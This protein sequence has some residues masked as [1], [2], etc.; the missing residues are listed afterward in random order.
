MNIDSEIGNR[1]MLGTD[2]LAERPKAMHQYVRI[3]ISQDWANTVCG[4]LIAECLVNLL[5][6][7]VVLV[8]QL[9]IVSTDVPLLIHPIIKGT[10]HTFAN[11]LVAVGEWSVGMKVQT[12]DSYSLQEPDQTIV[13]GNATS[14]HLSK[15]IACI[16]DGWKAWVGEPKNVP[17]GSAS[18]SPNP[19]G[20][21][22]TA[23]LAAGEI[24]KRT[25]GLR[26]GRYLDNHAYSLWNNSMGS[27]WEELDAGPE[28]D[29]LGLPPFVLVG[30]GAVGNALAYVLTHLENR[31]MYPVLIDDDIYDKT[32]LNRCSLAG[33]ENLTQEKTAVLA[34]RLQEA[35]IASFPFS[36]DLKRFVNDARVGMRTDV[37]E[38][39]GAGVY[40][41]VVSCVDK[42]DGRQDIQGLH[43]QWLLGGSTFDLQ[44]KTNFYGGETGAACLG[45]H[46][47]RENQGEAMR[48]IEHQLRAMSDQERSTYLVE[49]GLEAALVEEYIAH[50]QCGHLGRAA[51]MDFVSA[52]SPEFSVGFVSLGS[53][54][55]LAASMFRKLIVVEPTP[56]VSGMT[57]FNF[58]NGNLGE[59]KLARDPQCQLCSR[60]A[61]G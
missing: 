13:I 18:S 26:R 19:V 2:G 9:E 41:M 8:E 24:F 32:N 57:T 17:I 22:F 29:G 11:Y 30:A 48:A 55:L 16:A 15:T 36:G 37:A 45:C 35:G 50:P 47:P 40:R 46:N 28:L 5:S 33:A 7:Q 12:G 6:R 58:L 14:Q 34:L 21:L 27:T 59:S 56:H 38:E 31:D 44:A 51:L 42:G 53:G 20:P 54:I 10:W 43:S 61:F 25:W 52:P 60:A 49:H 23:A 4:Q 3:V 1:H 39:I